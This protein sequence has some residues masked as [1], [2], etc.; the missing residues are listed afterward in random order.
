MLHELISYWERNLIYKSNSFFQY[1]IIG[2]V[3]DFLVKNY[4]FFEIFKDLV[5]FGKK[6]PS[7]RWIFSTLL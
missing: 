3:Y 1:F 5:F 4:I 6:S 2:K 7:F